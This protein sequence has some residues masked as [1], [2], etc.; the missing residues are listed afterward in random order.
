MMSRPR[1]ASHCGS[2]NEKKNKRETNETKCKKKKIKKNSNNI[3][4]G[5]SPPPPTHRA[6]TPRRDSHYALLVPHGHDGNARAEACCVTATR[7]TFVRT[8]DFFLSF[9]FFFFYIFYFFFP[10][11]DRRAREIT[12]DRWLVMGTGAH[13]SAYRPTRHVRNLETAHPGLVAADTAN[14]RCP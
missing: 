7:P 14:L 13:G 8:G 3:S 11:T 5:S 4:T 12:R 6:R 1:Y 9:C 2:F 10:P